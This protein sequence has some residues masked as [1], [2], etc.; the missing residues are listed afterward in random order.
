MVYLNYGKEEKGAVL[1]KLAEQI[2]KFYTELPALIQALM[3]VL[4]FLVF[5][6]LVPIL[7]ITNS[8]SL[9]IWWS[10]I[11]SVYMLGVALTTGYVLHRRRIR[12][13]KALYGEDFVYKAFPR[14][15]ARDERKAERKKRQAE[16]ET[17]KRMFR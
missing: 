1:K 16:K 8:E 11:L 17:E 10:I 12:Q 2:G 4:V 13:L 7:L 6:A 5:Q 3:L 14:E 15:K 9:G